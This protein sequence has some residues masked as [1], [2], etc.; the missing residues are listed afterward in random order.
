VEGELDKPRPGIFST[1]QEEVQLKQQVA[2]RIE[3]DEALILVKKLELQKIKSRGED[4]YSGQKDAFS[5][6]KGANLFFTNP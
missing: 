3:K 1:S 5:Q 6:V 2:K 4:P